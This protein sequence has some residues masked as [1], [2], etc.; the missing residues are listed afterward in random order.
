M[1][2]VFIQ[3]AKN[4]RSK[5]THTKLSLA[6]ILHANAKRNRTSLST[7]ISSFWIHWMHCIHTSVNADDVIWMRRSISSRSFECRSEHFT[8]KLLRFL[9]LYFFF[10]LFPISS[11][12]T[13][14]IHIANGGILA[15]TIFSWW[16]R[17]TNGDKN[18]SE[19]WTE[20]RRVG[21]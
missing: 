3:L 2:S 20:I 9:S 1:N 4:Q 16:N 10:L 14:R 6:S 7:Q 12:Q 15:F 8:Y 13:P 21:E 19:W 17:W 5:K 18:E 11:Y